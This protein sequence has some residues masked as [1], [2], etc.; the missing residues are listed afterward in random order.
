MVSRQGR[1]RR[2]EG[3]R[4]WC[5]EGIEEG[6]EGGGGNEGGEEE[7]GENEEAESRRS[8]R[9]GGSH[10]P[11]TLISTCDL[12]ISLQKQFITHISRNDGVRGL[13]RTSAEDLSREP[14]RGGREVRGEER[15]L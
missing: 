4:W 10:T 3:G 2:E 8:K 14:V 7:V 1:D 12:I 9:E 11:L 6:G 15:R 13:C 5:D